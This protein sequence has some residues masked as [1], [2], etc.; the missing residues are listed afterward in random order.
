M[1]EIRVLR[2]NVASQIA[3]GEVIERPASIVREL[4]DNSL[5]AGAD[6]ITLKIER[7]G[8]RFIQVGDNGRGMGRDDLLLSVE[9]HATSKLREGED[10]FHIKTLGFRGEAL[11]SIA[12]VSRLELTSRKGEDLV[13]HRLVMAGGKLKSLDETG[14]PTGTT[15]VVRDLFYQMPARKKFLRT[16]RTETD[17][18][19]KTVSRIAIPFMGVHFSLEIG[20]KMTLLLSSTENM[21]DRLS[22]LFGSQVASAMVVTEAR[23]DYIKVNAF[24]APPDFTRTRADRILIYVNHRGIRDRFLTQ[25]VMEGY[26][27]RLMK[28]RYPQAVLLI[29]IDPTLVDVNVHP[30]KQEIRFRQGLLVSRFISDAINQLFADQYTTIRAVAAGQKPYG[31]ED[32]IGEGTVGEARPPY[33]FSEGQRSEEREAGEGMQ[34]PLARSHVRY[35]GQL[36]ETYLLFQGENGLLIVDQHA[37]HERV[38][39]ETLKRGYKKDVIERQGFLIPPNLEFTLQEARII[40]KNLDQLARMGL[41][42]DYFGGNTFLLR[43]VPSILQTVDWEAFLRE[44]IPHLE[45]KENLDREEAYDQFIALMACHNALRSGQSLSQ[46]E[47]TYLLEQLEGMSLPTHCPHGRPIFRNIGYREIDKMFGRLV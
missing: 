36:D 40:E 35:I 41:E 17:H 2:E 3:A 18:I 26:G 13:G 27:Q 39:Y 16:D 22:V 43:A 45:K 23:K 33:G 32:L 6:R 46:Q 28:G 31:G 8:K 47:I 29:D 9:R 20:G 44:L 12:S 21:V 1:G 37:A 7:G 30:A 4:I 25:A 38:V 10:L 15:V 5:D 34:V 24:L 11:P 19:L 14:A 42:M